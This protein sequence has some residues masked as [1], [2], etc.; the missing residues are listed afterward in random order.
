MAVQECKVGGKSGFKHGDGG[1]CY[2]HDG[3]KRGQ[4]ISRYKAVVQGLKS[5]K[6]GSLFREYA[7]LVAV[8]PTLASISYPE[9]EADAAESTG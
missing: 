8:D 2:T 3:T 1:T 9:T 4:R 6:G 7:Q 5:G